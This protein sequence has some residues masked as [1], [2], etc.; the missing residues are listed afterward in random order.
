M[1]LRDRMKKLRQ[2]QKGFTLVELIVVIAIIGILAGVM[3]PRFF[4]FTDDARD[5]AAIAE[6]KSIRSIGETYYA[7]MGEWPDVEVDEDADKSTV[8]A[9]QEY[10]FDGTITGFKAD[11]GGSF[12]YQKNNGVPLVTCDENG[13][14]TIADRD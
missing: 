13:N 12:T 9:D 1:E 2:K 8:D 3:L 6:A 4:G 14:I 10:E 7:K 11:D 5:A